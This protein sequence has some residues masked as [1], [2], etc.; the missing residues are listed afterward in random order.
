[1][2]YAISWPGNT[3]LARFFG[4]ITADDVEAVNHAFSGD[5]RMETV[6]F[7]I[8]DFSQA[9]SID[10]PEH[11]IEYAAAFDKGVSAVRPTLRGALIVNND[12][13]RKGIEKY[14]AIAD[15]LDVKWDT[16]IFDDMQ[17]ARNWLESHP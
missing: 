16:R 17:T 1:M 8:W 2:T 13:I 7:S 10:M 15:D 3:F 4:V 14:L 11:E 9:S 6:R 5:A 12:Q